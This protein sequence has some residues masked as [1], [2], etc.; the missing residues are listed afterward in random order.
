MSLHFSVVER[1]SL[2][3]E[4]WEIPYETF[5]N[6]EPLFFWLAGTVT[7]AVHY[8]WRTG[9]PWLE[10]QVTEGGAQKVASFSSPSKPSLPSLRAAIDVR[11]SWHELC[12]H[13]SQWQTGIIGRNKASLPWG[14]CQ[15]PAAAVTKA[16]YT[17]TLPVSRGI[18]APATLPAG[19]FRA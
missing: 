14:F 19:E 16:A 11:F 3:L 9:A 10:K 8:F 18:T 1:C 4:T 17:A 13:A 12:H 6:A 5:L 2:F 15:L 7:A